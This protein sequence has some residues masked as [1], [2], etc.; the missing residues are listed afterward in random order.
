M[1]S[2]K[3]IFVVRLVVLGAALIIAPVTAAVA[4]G[5]RFAAHSRTMVPALAELRLPAAYAE[6]HRDGLKVTFR[7]FLL[8]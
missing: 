8:D 7:A 4:S 1:H 3:L 5:V 2:S 6:L